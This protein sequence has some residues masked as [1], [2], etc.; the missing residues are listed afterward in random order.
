MVV[1]AV[2]HGVSAWRKAI[3]STKENVSADMLVLP[4][5]SQY[6][7]EVDCVRELGE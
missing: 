2:V 6:L 4:C 3:S 7:K 1:V 5:S